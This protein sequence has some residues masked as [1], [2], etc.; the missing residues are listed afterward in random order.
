M[1]PCFETNARDV[2]FFMKWI[3][4]LIYKPLE[5]LPYV[6][7][8]GPQM[9][10]KSTLIDALALINPDTVEITSALNRAMATATLCVVDETLPP[11]EW[12]QSKYLIL[13]RKDQRPQV[14]RNKTHWIQHSN[15]VRNCPTWVDVREFYM[16]R[17][18]QPCDKAILMN[19]LKAEIPRLKEAL[20]EYL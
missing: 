14:I 17:L 2:P 1:E 7:L 9:G 15:D 12:V 6:F 11:Q 5:P 3:A 4:S 19:A 8:Y 10:G 20:N 18:T 13:T 16:E